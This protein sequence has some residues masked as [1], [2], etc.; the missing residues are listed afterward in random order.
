MRTLGQKRAEF[1]LNAVLNVD[2]SLEKKKEFKTFQLGHR[3]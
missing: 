2:E 1:S 3:Q